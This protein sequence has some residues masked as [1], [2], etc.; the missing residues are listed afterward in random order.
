MQL[1]NSIIFGHGTFLK[2]FEQENNMN[3]LRCKGYG[4]IVILKIVI[5]VSQHLLVVN[6]FSFIY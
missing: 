3:R 5:L 1:E 6:I 4:K 2:I